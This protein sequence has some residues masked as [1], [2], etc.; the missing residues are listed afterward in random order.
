VALSGLSHGGEQLDLLEA[1]RR[2]R[3]DKL[4]KATD[5]LRDKFGFGSVQF[6]GSLRRD[7]S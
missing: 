1:D 2:E 3:L 4:T 5:S 6:G 7:D